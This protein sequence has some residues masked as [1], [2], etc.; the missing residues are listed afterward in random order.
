MKLTDEYGMSYWA[1]DQCF[2]ERNDIPEIRSLINCSLPAYMYCRYVK[3]IEELWTK[4]N[5][6][7]WAKEYCIYV[8]DRPEVRR[9]IKDE[10][11]R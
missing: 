8:K 6:S 11:N 1:F 5:E 7:M 3:D 4:I 2:F 9:Y 10:I